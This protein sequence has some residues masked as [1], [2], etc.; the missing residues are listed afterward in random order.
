M[1]KLHRE[2][3]HTITQSTTCAMFDFFLQRNVLVLV[4]LKSIQYFIRQCVRMN[5]KD[6]PTCVLFLTIY[7]SLCMMS[8][9]EVCRGIQ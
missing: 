5:A 1:N 3:S 9:A 6:V 4:Q 2:K 7:F 8:D